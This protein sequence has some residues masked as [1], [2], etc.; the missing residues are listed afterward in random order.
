MSKDKVSPFLRMKWRLNDRAKVKDAYY[1]VKSIKEIVIKKD[2]T[3]E[4][5]L[6]AQRHEKKEEQIRLIGFLECLKWLIDG[7]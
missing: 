6:A 4:E 7:G 5:L 3:Y 2:E 1:S